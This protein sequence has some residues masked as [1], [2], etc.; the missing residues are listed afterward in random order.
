MKGSGLVVLAPVV[1]ACG[2][3]R[4]DLPKPWEGR[5]VWLLLS[6][7]LLVPV[8]QVGWVERSW[9]AVGPDAGEHSKRPRFCWS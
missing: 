5:G 9:A 3:P 1:L 6:A 4:G 7:P 2:T 8:R